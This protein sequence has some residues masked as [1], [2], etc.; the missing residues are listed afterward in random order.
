MMECGEE[1]LDFSE[2]MWDITSKNIP[3]SVHQQSEICG[4]ND[5][6]FGHTFYGMSR[7]VI[8]MR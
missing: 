5:D 1:G 3:F 7:D 6:T 8:N 4:F 2:A